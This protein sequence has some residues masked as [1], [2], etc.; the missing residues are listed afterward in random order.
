MAYKIA[1]YPTL[2]VT[3]TF[4]IVFNIISQSILK[5]ALDYGIDPH[6]KEFCSSVKVLDLNQNTSPIAN[7]S[8]ELK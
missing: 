8:D 1:K 5:A 7:I 4:V 3:I 6:M 2:T